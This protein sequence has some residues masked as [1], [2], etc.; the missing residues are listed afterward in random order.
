MLESFTLETFAPLVGSG[1]RL[2]APG[3]PID[4]VLAE[5]TGL[6]PRPRSRLP[7]ALL[8]RQPAGVLVPQQ[9]YPVDHPDLGAFELFIVPLGPDAEGMRYEAVF[10]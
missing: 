8:F 5:A 9:A 2:H 10:G 3:G 4:L 1:F 6:P 7:F